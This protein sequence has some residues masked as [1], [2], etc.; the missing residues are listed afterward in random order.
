M[1][2]EIVIAGSIQAV[3]TAL[4]AVISTYR[5]SREVRK[6]E[7]EVLRTRLE[8]VH[9][10]LRIQGNANLARASIEEIIVTQRLVDGG[11][12]SGK[13]LEFALEHMFRLSQY[14]I[15]VVEAY[16]RR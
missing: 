12:L 5:G 15:R 2:Q 16:A 7:M 13:A 10:L 1:A 9:A 8:E 14:N 11:S 6:S 4:A 3:G